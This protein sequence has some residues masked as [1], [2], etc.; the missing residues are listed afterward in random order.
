[1]P[2]IDLGSLNYAAIAVAGFA[3]F[4]LGGIWYTA[5]AGPWTRMNGFTPEKA[6]QMKKDRPPQLFFGGMIGSYLVLALIVAIVAQ[7]AGVTTLGSGIMLGL[8]LW[9]GP[10]ACI[11]LTN[12]IASDKPIGV[13]FID[14]AYQFVYLL[15]MGAIV[16]AWR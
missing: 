9:V 16:G 1:M 12:W 3:A 4:F 15:L 2:A 8:L 5:L 13:F 10:A 14:A 6:E 11:G 7:L